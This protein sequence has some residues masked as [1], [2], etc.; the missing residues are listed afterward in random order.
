MRLEA[1]IG[2]VSYMYQPLLQENSFGQFCEVRGQYRQFIGLSFRTCCGGR[3]LNKARLWIK[4]LK[5]LRDQNHVSGSLMGGPFTY[6]KKCVITKPY[7]ASWRLFLLS[8][9]CISSSKQEFKRCRGSEHTPTQLI[10]VYCRMIYRVDN[11][12][13][14]GEKSLNMVRHHPWEAYTENGDLSSNRYSS[15]GLGSTPFDHCNTYDFEKE[16]RERDIQRRSRWLV[17]VSQDDSTCMYAAGQVEFLS[18]LQE[19]SVIFPR[20]LRQINIGFLSFFLN[21]LWRDSVIHIVADDI[22]GCKWWVHQ[23]ISHRQ[24]IVSK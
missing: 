4:C 8:S 6:Y 18:T 10:H 14:M 23:I 12:R 20:F 24:K 1:V 2:S 13:T 11:C 22:H 15:G 21:D 16:S 5:Q 9:A 17:V 3:H 19:F 7:S